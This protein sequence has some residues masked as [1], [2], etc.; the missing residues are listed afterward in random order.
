MGIYAAGPFAKRLLAMY[1]RVVGKI[2]FPI[3]FFDSNSNKWGKESVLEGHA[4]YSPKQIRDFGITKIIIASEAFY[5]EIYQSIKYL[6]A[7]GIE[8][9][10]A[11]IR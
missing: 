2:D 8:I 10:A 3:F 5:E 1:E 11:G 4:V 9:C 7:Y 6:E